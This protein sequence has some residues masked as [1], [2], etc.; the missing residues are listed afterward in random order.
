VIEAYFGLPYVKYPW[1]ESIGV[2]RLETPTP[3]P[4]VGAEA[5]ETPTPAP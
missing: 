4:E 1:E 5:T 3:T 2:P